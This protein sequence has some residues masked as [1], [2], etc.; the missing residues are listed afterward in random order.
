MSFS[1]AWAEAHFSMCYILHS[2]FYRNNLYFAAI[3]Y[4]PFLN[5]TEVPVILNPTFFISFNKVC[6]KNPC[7]TT[8][9]SI[10]SFP[11]IST[12]SFARSLVCLR[13]STCL[14]EL[15][16]HCKRPVRFQ[17][18]SGMFTFVSKLDLSGTSFISP[19]SKYSPFRNSFFAVS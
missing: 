17:N 2:T 12:N 15:T 5:F 11:I 6:I 4:S 1:P 9:T 7:V 8:A 16:N 13:P 14:P 3:T 19:D 18:H 10:S